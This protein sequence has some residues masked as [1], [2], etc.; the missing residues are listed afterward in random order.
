MTQ[1]FPLI[2][3]PTLVYIIGRAHAMILLEHIISI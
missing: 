3:I 1:Y 2:Y